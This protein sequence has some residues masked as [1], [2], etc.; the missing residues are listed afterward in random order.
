MQ[1]RDFARTLLL[2]AS[3]ACTLALPV[4]RNA[5]AANPLGSLRAVLAREQVRSGQARWRHI[6]SCAADTCTDS[7]RVRIDIEAITFAPTLPPLV[8]DAMVDTHVGLRP[9]RIASFQPE[10]LSPA[11][12]P[13]S[14]EIER[15]GLA[16]FRGELGQAGTDP[17]RIGSVAAL[18]PNRP[19]LLPGRYLLAFAESAS[20]IDL[21]ALSVAG[22]DVSHA[23]SSIALLIFSVRELTA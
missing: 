16:G 3:A 8:I 1:R 2:G 17:L 18:S 4:S 14:F 10:S 23:P 9:F 19:E 5:F 22:F 15:S 20:D 6:E 21:D 7:P 12:K 11:S 13:F